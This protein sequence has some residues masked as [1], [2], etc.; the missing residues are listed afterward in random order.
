MRSKLQP[1]KQTS[2]IYVL[3]NYWSELHTRII[4]GYSQTDLFICQRRGFADVLV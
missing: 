3:G 2:S 4:S 1:V